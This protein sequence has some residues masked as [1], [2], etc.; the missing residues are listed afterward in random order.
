VSD[1]ELEQYIFGRLQAIDQAWRGGYAEA[2]ILCRQ[3][4]DK[5]LWRGR[6]KSFE[7]Y[8]KVACPFGYAMAYKALA[9]VKALADIPDSDLAQMKETTFGVLRQL[10]SKVRALPEVIEVAKNKPAAELVGYIRANH[11]AQ[12]LE[13]S[14][15]LRFTLDESAAAKVYEALKMAQQ[16][17]AHNQNVAIEEICVEWMEVKRYEKEVEDAC[18]QSE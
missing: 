1:T 17:G 18:Q 14:V 4:H 11:P 2:G 6:A 10:S 8:V 5:L 7:E 15:T 13:S 16:L 12:H 9:D 3:I